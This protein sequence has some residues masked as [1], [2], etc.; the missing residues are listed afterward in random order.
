MVYFGMKLHLLVI[1]VCENCV[2][3]FLK[4]VRDMERVKLT[5]SF[6]KKLSVGI[7][8]RYADTETPGLQLRVS[9]KKISYYFMISARIFFLRGLLFLPINYKISI[10][11]D[12]CL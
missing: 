6:V 3:V 7:N 5:V 10:E 1:F 8:V 4:G 11:K 9:S 12:F 2:I